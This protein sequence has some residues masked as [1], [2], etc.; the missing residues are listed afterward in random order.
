MAIEKDTIIAETAWFNGQIA[1]LDE[2]FIQW[3]KK[4]GRDVQNSERKITKQEGISGEYT[5]SENE[6]IVDNVLKITLVPYGIW[7]IAAQG[8]IDIVGPSGSEKLVYLKK[9]DSATVGEMSSVFYHS[10]NVHHQFNNIAED[11]WYWYDDNGIRKMIKLR[12]KVFVSLLG[13]L[14]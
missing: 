4:D 5:T 11:G 1:R 6:L 3:L 14:Q 7:I 2:A 13:R 12:K 8:R 10:K 9:G